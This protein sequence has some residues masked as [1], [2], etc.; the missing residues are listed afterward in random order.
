M[1]THA[2]LPSWDAIIA[3]LLTTLTTLGVLGI[4]GVAVASSIFTTSTSNMEI[5]RAALLWAGMS[6]IVAFAAGGYVAAV[7]VPIAAG[8]AQRGLLVGCAALVVVMGISFAWGSSA[9]D[10]RSV[11]IELGWISPAEPERPLVPA[12][13][14]A[15]RMPEELQIIPPGR[16]LAAARQT[17]WYAATAMVLLVGAAIL[18]GLAGTGARQRTHEQPSRAN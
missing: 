13:E 2:G 3:G 4:L 7:A 16:F 5:T 1:K 15:Q 14:E 9:A 18:G 10:F 8:A 17:L 12:A 6:A 11:G